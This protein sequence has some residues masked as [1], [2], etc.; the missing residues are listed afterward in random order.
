[1]EYGNVYHLITAKEHT[2]W[3]F[4]TLPRLHLVFSTYLDEEFDNSIKHLSDNS[5]IKQKTVESLKESNIDSRTLYD[6]M[7]IFTPNHSKFADYCQRLIK[8]QK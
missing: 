3:N 8:E 5:I 4:G 7:K 6:L 1:M 2:A